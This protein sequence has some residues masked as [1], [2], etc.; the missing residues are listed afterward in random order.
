MH[1]TELSVKLWQQQR[2]CLDYYNHTAAILAA[3][4]SR[5]DTVVWD[6]LN[7]HDTDM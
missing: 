1:T 4:S 3:N 2:R 5:E 7:K 6:M